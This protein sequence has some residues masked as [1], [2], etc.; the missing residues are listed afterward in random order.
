MRR[1]FLPV[2]LLVASPAAAATAKDEVAAAAGPAP[3]YADPRYWSA[4]SAALP[5]GA[6][7]SATAA[8]VDVFYV[9]P[10]TM[11]GALPWNQDVNDAAANRV[12]DEGTVA[13]QASA[14]TGCCRVYAPRYRAAGPGSLMEPAHRDA[15]F[16]LA[17]SDV[18]RAFDWFLQ[19][20]SK[21][22]PFIIAGHSQGAMH[23]SGLLERRI[24]GTPLQKRMV[25]AYIIG[26]NLAE[27]EFGLRYKS[28]LACRTPAQTGCVVQWNA[29]A[30]GSNLDAISAAFEKPFVQKY[31][32]APGRQTLCVNPVTYDARRPS[33]L[34]SQSKGAAPGD[35]GLGA[36]RP[37]Q[38]GKV[39]V[40]CQRG[41]AVTWY[42]PSLD[43][44][45]LPGG[46]LHYHD[47]G[48]FWA[49]LRANA[50]L[51]ARTWLS[52]HGKGVR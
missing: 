33:A 23:L 19:N 13:R 18:E 9:H 36:M 6:G 44:K 25:A 48:L 4:A 34:S 35:A 16:A 40:S 17:Y 24:D 39:A 7:P 1:C 3:D 45:A 30:A 22:R 46:S 8:G 12:V 29:V 21:G 15:A 51:R 20:V 50:V 10:T 14:F 32:E 2:L 27:G 31:G 43:L 47:I 26:I 5:E 42:S 37:L 28:A 41:I 11:R 38:P 49:D 52:S